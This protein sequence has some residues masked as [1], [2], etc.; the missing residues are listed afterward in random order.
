MIFFLYLYILGIVV[1]YCTLIST[2]GK[3]S[4]RFDWF[5]MSLFWPIFFDLVF[6][7]R[8]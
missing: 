2:S 5:M 3:E 7:K 8:K 6:K 1:F 4:G